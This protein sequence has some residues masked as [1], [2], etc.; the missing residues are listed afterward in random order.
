MK[1]KSLTTLALSAFII[2]APGISCSAEEDMTPPET[3]EAAP[4]LPDE[5]SLPLDAEETEST[6]S[7][8]SS[9]SETESSET[10]DAP[11][12]E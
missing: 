12:A 11:P 5:D 10:E 2:M 8:E 1:T 3:E 9:E 4:I 6:D 7:S